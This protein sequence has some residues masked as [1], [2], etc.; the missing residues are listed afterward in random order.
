LQMVFWA[1]R[2]STEW[3]RKRD[4]NLSICSLWEPT[5]QPTELFYAVS[6]SH[7]KCSSLGTFTAAWWKRDGREADMQLHEDLASWDWAAQIGE[8]SP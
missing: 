4:V 5:Y 6:Q 1:T 7:I 2:L 3:M 8:N